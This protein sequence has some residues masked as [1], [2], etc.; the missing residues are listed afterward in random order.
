MARKKSRGFK[1]RLR[2]R[3]RKTDR[4]PCQKVQV[5]RKVQRGRGRKLKMS[6]LG[7]N[8]FSM[9]GAVHMQSPGEVVHKRAENSG[10]PAMVWIYAEW[11]GHCH[12]FIPTWN[13]IVSEFPDVKF[14]MVN[15][16]NQENYPDDYPRVRGYPTLWLMRVGEL[17]PEEYSGGRDLPTLRG[18]LTDMLNM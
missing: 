13:K 5:R 6:A 1:K 17:K 9:P 12:K 2:I 7:E 4:F 10:S 3:C 15:G 8:P 14:M 18:V 16:D 11:C